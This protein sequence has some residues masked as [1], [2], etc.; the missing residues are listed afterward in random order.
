MLAAGLLFEKINLN[1]LLNKPAFRNN[2]DSLPDFL[3]VKAYDNTLY[4]DYLGN[5][6]RRRNR[7]ERE[8]FPKAMIDFIGKRILIKSAQNPLIILK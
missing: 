3:T 5:Y 8:I 2:S 1:N 4:K 7:C 6:F